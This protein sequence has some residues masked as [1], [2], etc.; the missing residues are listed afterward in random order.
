MRVRVVAG[1]ERG[2]EVR[3]DDL[4]QHGLDVAVGAAVL[5]VHG[6][7]D[8]MAKAI[9]A[10]LLRL[11][12]DQRVEEVGHAESVGLPAG[13]VGVERGQVGGIVGKELGERRE[14][15]ADRIDELGG[16]A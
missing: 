1:L 2:D 10:I 5:R 16:A 3:P 4:D 11:E 14:R 12:G 13:E 9:H 15:R 6:E 8:D 7:D